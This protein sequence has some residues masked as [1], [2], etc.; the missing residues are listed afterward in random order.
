VSDKLVLVEWLDSRRG[1]GWTHIEEL[2]RGVPPTK[3]RSVG[4]IVARDRS[5]LTLASHLGD[6]PDQ[7]CG[8]IT[9]PTKAVLAVITLPDPK[10]IKKPTRVR[11]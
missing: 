6:N 9:I 2:R 11:R 3:C 4:W 10:A 7:C 5:A 8:D 1:E